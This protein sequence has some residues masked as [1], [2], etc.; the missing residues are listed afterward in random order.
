MQLRDVQVLKL[1]D[2]S[3][4]S[5]L[6]NTLKKYRECETALWKKNSRLVT[7][8]TAKNR[9][10]EFVNPKKILG[11]PM[12]FGGPFT[13]PNNDRVT[14]FL[15]HTL[16]HEK[17]QRK[18]NVFHQTKLVLILWTVHPRL[19][20]NCKLSQLGRSHL[21]FIISSSIFNALSFTGLRL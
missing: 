7:Q 5:P 17:W 15:R 10:S 19:A 9:H 1:S 11:R 12:V 2:V 8:I 14:K 3:N 4:K 16:D 13:N 18:H 6:R 20:A 21:A